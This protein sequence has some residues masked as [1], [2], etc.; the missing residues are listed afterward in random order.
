MSHTPIG[1]DASPLLAAGASAVPS[2]LDM[3]GAPGRRSNSV[4]VV[5]SLVSAA[6]EQSNSQHKSAASES[7]SQRTSSVFR[8]L[9][10]EF[11]K[12]VRGLHFVYAELAY[13]GLA[14]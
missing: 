13:H 4:G 14:K 10:D 9:K 2:P 5:G 1:N 7:W 8:I 3:F 6:D 11:S 12:N